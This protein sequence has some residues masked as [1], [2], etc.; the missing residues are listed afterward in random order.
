[1]EL[2]GKR[3]VVTG[4]AGFIGSH[5]AKRLLK[6]GAIVTIF[7]N[8]VTGSTDNIQDFKDDIVLIKGDVKNYEEVNKAIRNQNFVVHEAFPYA[9]V[10]QSVED[11]FIEDSYIGTFNVLKAS[12][13]NDVEKVVYGSSVAVYG[14]QQYL[15]VDEEHPKNP[16]YPYGVTKYACEKLCTSF[17]NAYELS[18][19][20]LRYFNVYGPLFTNLDHSAVLSFVKRVVEGEPPLIY[21]T[22]E[23]IRDFTYI[24]DII[25]GTVLAIT[26]DTEP[27]DV[28]NLGAGEGVKIIDLARKIVEISK[29]TVKPRLA[30]IEEYRH[31]DRT[32]PWGMT[33]IVDGKYIDTRN[34]IADIKKAR[35][36]LRYEPKVSQDEG[37]RRT[38]LWVEEK[39]AKQR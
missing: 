5:L 2:K 34:Y 25:D 13:Y 22:G 10:S 32:L 15:P 3:V 30:Q 1:M 16:D 36:L 18:T 20:S 26:Q 24:D 35:K 31:Y 33:E 17:S 39:F 23:Q 14:K 4:G 38:L 21:G 12:L 27:G 6:M 11:Q 28:F 19:V 29:K 37:I 7:D 8:F 9:M